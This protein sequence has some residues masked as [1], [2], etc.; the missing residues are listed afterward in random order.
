M[1]GHLRLR[2]H[3]P[4]I[5]RTI[6]LGSL[7]CGVG[8]LN[9]SRAQASALDLRTAVIVCPAQLSKSEKKALD[10]LVE[11][12]QRRTLIRW[13]VAH[14]WPADSTPVIAVGPV[15]QLADFAGRYLQKLAKPLEKGTVPLSSKGQSPFPAPGRERAAEGFRICIARDGRAAPAVFVIG[16]DSRGMLFG[17]GRLLRELQMAR[18]RVA[19]AADLNVSTA[20]KFPLRGHQLGYRPKTNS[21]DGWNLAL[22]EQYIRDLAV[23]GTNAVELIPPRSDD[24]ADSPHFPLP[25]L[26]MMIGMSKLLDDYG[27]DVWIWYPAM[28]ADYSKPET[29]AFALKEWGEIFKK[30]PRIDAVFVP[31]G[32]PGHTRP[33]YLMALLEKQTENLHR[34]H[35]KAQMWVSPQGFTREWLDEFYAILQKEQPAWLSGVVYGPQVRVSLPQLRAA[36]PTKYP[37]RRYPDI[38]HSLRCQYPVPD[39]D[40]AYAL[41][42]AREV[43]NPRPRGEAAIFRALKDQAIGFITYSE[44][45]NDDVNKIVWSSLGWD[46][47]TKVID[48]L[49]QYS[50]YF[51]GGR[52]REIFAQGLLALEKN[53]QGPLLTNESVYTTLKQFQEME[54]AATPQ[55]LLNWRFQQAL[56]RAYYDAY[57]RSRLLYE[58]ELEERAL[59]KLRAAKRLGSLLALKKAEA[60]LDRCETEKVATDWSARVHELAEAL[61][62]SIRMQ[63]NVERYKAIS[64]GRG[65]NLDTIDVPL[66]NRRWLKRQFAAL[67]QLEFES[68]R[69]REIGKIVNWTNPGPGGFYDDLGNPS[70][71]PHLVRGP[72]FAKDPASYQSSLVGFNYMPEG[73]LSWC[74]HAESL[75][76]APLQMRYRGLDRQAQYKVR[77]VCAGDNFRARV[78]LVAN[79]TTEIHPLRAKPSPVQPIEFDIPKTATAKGE[80]ELSWYQEPGRGGSGRGCQ[81]AEVWLIRK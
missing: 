72:G 22:W 32:D 74:T 77:V 80:L 57:E 13:E 60:I 50:Q 78:R 25:P 31:G 67:R 18:G 48:I 42:E 75:Y 59:E 52:Y 73:R 11:E 55:D 71:Q 9:G 20:P 49:R 19:L 79:G 69:L 34:Y 7:A 65:A 76:D 66:N 1:K 39:W 23:F 38:T 30:L 3:A 4:S 33:K 81:V 47:N 58:T 21:Y 29:V 45:C 27:L 56:Y 70:C 14:S 28:D 43:I 63:L 54:K 17:V 51:L 26:D 10:L 8:V 16:N 36:V 40:L 2:F 62:Q 46:P 68:D 6:L 12:A 24:A 41:T 35:P 64:V 44:G 15:T 61:Y 53:W 37:I 5:F